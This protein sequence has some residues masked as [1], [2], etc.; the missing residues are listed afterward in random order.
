LA[1]SVLVEGAAVT[2]GRYEIRR[3]I[4]RGR[5]GVV[6]EGRDPALGRTIALK[7]IPASVSSD[8]SGAFE[9]RF[10]DE[11]RTAARLCHPGIAAIHDAGRDDGT[12]T[13]Y[14]ALEYLEGPTLE[15]VIRERGPLDWHE[16]LSIV[17]RVAEALHH[18]HSRGVAHRDLT[19]AK[20]LLLPSG[21]KIMG[22]GV[23]GAGTARLRLTETGLPEDAPLHAAPEL[24][25]GHMV[26]GRADV[27]SL[28]SIAYSLLT[29]R[30]AFEAKSIAEVARR[31]LEED[32]PPPSRLVRSLPADV[33][34]LVGRAL[35]KE[36][37]ERYPTAGALA[38]DVHDILAGAPLRHRARP[39]DDVATMD[40]RA[41]L[42]ALLAESTRRSSPAPATASATPSRRS[43][44]RPMTAAVALI[45]LL[46]ASAIRWS[47]RDPN[48]A[49]S[50][51]P[52]PSPE[53][54]LP[55]V[56]A[57][58][59]VSAP[60]RAA[61][62][63]PRQADAAV[64]S[65]A[66]RPARLAID[67]E[68]PL[69]RGRLR[70]WV[71]GGL[72]LRRGLEGRVTRNLIAFKLRSGK[73]QQALEVEPGA[74]E[75]QVQIA[76]GDEERWARVRGSFP[77]GSTRRLAVHLGRVWKKLSLEWE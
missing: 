37:A 50:P 2:L 45:V 19:P 11:A 14:I 70:V 5:L 40:L 62:P 57:A 26:D 59:A 77:S 21:P 67:V 55:V 38:E 4:G 75:V 53:A 68:H 7:T 74:H 20:V 12:G 49:A 66:T 10:L 28:G 48:P 76:W 23:G 47:A 46:G 32:P 29:A 42:S 54:A 58:P 39:L 3:E 30:L 13:L 34:A 16:G 25:L 65:S 36:P 24:L 35:A 71:D 44:V 17:L 1:R 51:A 61:R 72:V 73:A 31:V 18:A 15:E 60:P 43:R 63:L 9:R 6:Y 64:A 33:D 22:F 56:V 69:E 52:L 41:E 27:F 8:E